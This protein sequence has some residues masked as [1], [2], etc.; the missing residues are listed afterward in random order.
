MD[1]KV[2]SSEFKNWSA[3]SEE[4]RSFFIGDKYLPLHKNSAERISLMKGKPARNFIN[5]AFYKLPGYST[6]ATSEFKE[7]KSIFI[8]DVWGDAEKTQK[9]REWLYHC[10]IPFS[11]T[12]YLLYDHE[13]VVKT[14]WKTL[15]RFWDAFSWSVGIAM[16][17]LDTTKQWACEFHHEDLI[18]FYEYY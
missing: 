8:I 12:V 16:V 15:L 17:A 4:E 14:D 3:L 1:I 9:V 13:K 11:R 5:E 6:A 2:Y 10:A 18:T 7:E